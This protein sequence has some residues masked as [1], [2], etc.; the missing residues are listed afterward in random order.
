MACHRHSRHPCGARV[1][2]G[3]FRAGLA[4][5]E[6]C[7]GELNGI[8]GSHR[9]DFNCCR[10]VLYPS[11]EGFFIEH[12][13]I[14]GDVETIPGHA[15][16]TVDA[17]SFHID[18]SPIH[19]LWKRYHVFI[20]E[21]HGMCQWKCEIVSIFT[22]IQLGFQVAPSHSANGCLVKMEMRAP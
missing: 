10:H 19:S 21:A 6:Q 1:P 22:K 20:V 12:S 14:N 9:N 5:A 18:I 2:A 7:R 17:R 3:P 8:R 15:K 4:A 16:E 11:K 13:V